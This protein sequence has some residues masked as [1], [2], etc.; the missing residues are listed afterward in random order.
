M[1]S[2]TMGVMAAPGTTE[3]YEV[4]YA[5]M[6]AEQ[7]EA[8][9]TID[10]P[11][12]VIAGPG[13]G[14][15][16]ILTLRIANILRRT[17]TPPE[18]IL[19]L[20]FTEAGAN[21]MRSRLAKM[22]GTRGHKVRIHT[23]HGF[24]ESL[25]SRYP[26]A[27]SRI[28]G[29]EIATDVERAEMLDEA[30]LNTTVQYLRPFGDPLYYHYEA[31]R[32]ISTMK[33]ENVTP[34]V[35]AQKIAIAEQEYEAIPE[36]VHTKG[37]YEGKLKG[38]YES[39]Q[40]KIAKTR[41][42]LA[43]YEAYEAQLTEHHRYDYEDVILEAVRALT[44]DEGFRRE[45]QESIFYVHA[46]EHQDA[47]RAQNALLELLVEHDERP[48]LFVLG[49]EK[50]AIY[51]F[52]GAD[53]DNV[54]YFRERFPDTKIIA[55]IANYRSHQTILDSAL[56]LIAASPDTRLSRVALVA[57]S[58]ES[59]KK[60]IKEKNGKGDVIAPIRR[61]ACDTPADEMD[62]LAGEIQGLLNDGVSTEEIAVLVR[63]NQDVSYVAGSL[64]GMGIPVGMGT[65]NALQ[66][67][68]VRVLWRL[69]EA[70]VE[71]K[72]ENLGA[73]FTLPGFAL[74]GADVWR[75]MDYA[76]REKMPALSILGNTRM[77]E[78]AKVQNVEGAMKL[79]STLDELSRL[80]AVERP[81][82]VAQAALAATGMMDSILLASD[83]SETLVAIRELLD[84]FEELSQREHDALLPRGLAL[85]KLHEKRNLPLT[86]KA[87]ETPGLVRVMTVHRAK[88][89]EFEYVYVPV[90]TD[91]AWSTRN[92]PEHFYLPDILSGS[93]ELE[94]ERRLLYVAMTRAKRA[95]TLSYAT[96][97]E[98]GREEIAC[99]LLEEIDPT[100]IAAS[101]W[102]SSEVKDDAALLVQQTKRAQKMLKPLHELEPSTDDLD[103]LRRAFLAYGLSP[104]G[105]NN[106]L[107]CSWK[108]FY[109]NLLRIPEAEN[110]YMLYGTAIH[111]ALKA[112][113][114]RRTRGEDVPVTYAIENFNIALRRAP[115]TTRDIEELK[116]KGTKALTAWW[117]E[118]QSSW[119][120]KTESEFAV[121]TSI[122]LNDGMSLA[123][124]GNIDRMDPLPGSVFSVVD[125]KTGKVRS[126][127]ELMGKTKDADGNYYRQLIF[128]KLL[129]AGADPSREMSEGII[130][131]VEPDEGGKI[132]SEK[133]D[134]SKDEVTQ[135]ESDIRKAADEIL[136][137]SFWNTPCPD[138]ECGWCPFR[139]TT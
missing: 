54:H 52:Q 121:E 136:T 38:E 14:K 116:V 118:H 7:K 34:E 26:D 68:F 61:V 112:Y 8:V 87:Q 51:R 37:K 128:Y 83:R 72:E 85:L 132:R 78:A 46:D 60:N 20:T 82:V 80:A 93:V 73:L 21:E 1:K 107:Q 133:F 101:E 88:G 4:A 16:Q 92:R 86:R 106:Y 30:I 131:F 138:A 9:E 28:V 124:R 66:N 18:T 2:S 55:L 134:I 103:T 11:V 42:L 110:K 99:A 56:S 117:T 17:D 69:L 122:I 137:L 70:V 96:T 5:R 12:F 10:G 105:F 126:K 29:G 43:V 27:F 139:F 44:T 22:I 6:N 94:D 63:R 108:Y 113:A 53:L 77:L 62:F 45:V 23:F 50:Q 79:K 111:K 47:N 58:E 31:S 123:L 84:S 97:R 32:T 41:D 81:A 125:Y 15:T 67:R 130:E 48:N 64:S 19:A 75:M 13:T 119:P 104:T 90:L 35:L 71:P 127:N 115:L 65:D 109:V 24:A 25:I 102:H 57:S 100:L 33:R 49:D 98:D 95:V 114:D 89:R 74:S 3:E 40:K 59:A 120:V 129:L 135:L 76:R 36:K 39:L 91:R